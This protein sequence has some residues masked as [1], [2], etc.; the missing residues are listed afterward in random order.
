MLVVAIFYFYSSLAGLALY[1]KVNQS[2]QNQILEKVSDN[3]TRM[4][5]G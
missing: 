3:Q 1:C 2:E 5:H 4:K